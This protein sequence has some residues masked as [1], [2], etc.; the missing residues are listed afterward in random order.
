MKLVHINLEKESGRRGRKRQRW[1]GR[2][3][4]HALLLSFPLTCCPSTK[5]EKT[6]YA[7]HSDDFRTYE[8]SLI[9]H[10]TSEKKIPLPN[11][12]WGPVHP[13]VTLFSFMQSGIVRMGGCFWGYLII[14][15]NPDLLLGPPMPHSTSVY[16]YFQNQ[17]T[18][19]VWRRPLYLQA[20]L[21][22]VKPT[23][24]LSLFHSVAQD[25]SFRNP[26]NYS[27]PLT[28]GQPWKCLRLLM[29]P[30]SSIPQIKNPKSCLMY[31]FLYSQIHSTHVHGTSMS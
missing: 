17:K 5:L 30:T 18:P 21:T 28:S 14:S 1:K 20:F 19:K 4:I 10:Q 16:S 29:T 31:P 25:Q 3:I 8:L 27:V 12:S 24:P 9:T 26:R 15:F 23:S 11:N 2:G 6:A 7:V 22:R 13:A